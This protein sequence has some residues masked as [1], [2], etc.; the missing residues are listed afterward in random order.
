MIGSCKT[1]LPHNVT[2]R[3]EQM[4]LDFLHDLQ[5]DLAQI[6]DHSGVALRD[7]PIT[8][9]GTLFRTIL[10]FYPN[11]GRASDIDHDLS[12][13]VKTIGFELIEVE[14]RFVLAYIS[15]PEMKIFMDHFNTALQSILQNPTGPLRDVN[16]VSPKERQCIIVELNPIYSPGTSLSPANNVTELIEQQ[17]RKTPQRIAVCTQC[18]QSIPACHRCNPFIQLQFDQEQFIT[19]HQLDSFANNLALTLIGHNVQRGELVG[20]YMD[21]SC[22]MFISILAIH[23]AAAGYVPL[24]PAHPAERIQT[25]LDL[26]DIKIVLTGKLLQSQFDSHTSA[27][28]VA[29][30]VVDIYE[31]FPAGKPDLQIGRDD[32][33]H[34]LFTS[35]STGLP[36]GVEKVLCHM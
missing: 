34:V 11:D 26:A 31:L 6:D 14:A 7:I 12:F 32:I 21:K 13:L 4:T 35:G 19:Y 29:S 22:E 27:S 24:A 33:S 28:G 25:I 30:L 18:M 3:W 9:I 5:S 17:A 8:G 23:K 36:K 16:L 1:V 15:E 10:D 20:I 2:F